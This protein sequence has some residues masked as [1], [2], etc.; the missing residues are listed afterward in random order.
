VAAETSK[1]FIGSCYR[2]RTNGLLTT[3][4]C[5]RRSA[6]TKALNWQTSSQQQQAD[7]QY[8][9]SMSHADVETRTVGI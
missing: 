2:D 6:T 8:R 7:G 5:L 4:R 1:M 3:R 9:M